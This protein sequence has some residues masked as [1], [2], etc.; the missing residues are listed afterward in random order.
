[1]LQNPVF[2]PKIGEKSGLI[3]IAKRDITRLPDERFSNSLLF[4]EAD[5][6]RNAKITKIQ[7]WKTL[8][9]SYRYDITNS[10]VRPGGP[11]ENSTQNIVQ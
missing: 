11:F 8:E 6:S 1:M 9:F 5:T 7:I 10:V 2:L 3:I 4:C